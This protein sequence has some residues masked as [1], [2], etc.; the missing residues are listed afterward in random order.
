MIRRVGT[1]FPSYLA[2]NLIF[3]K[4]FKFGGASIETVDRARNVA[5]L[6]REFGN[7]SLLVVISAKG[8]TTNALEKVVDAYCLG[9]TADAQQLFAELK[10]EHIAYAQS[11]LGSYPQTLSDKLDEIAV[12]AE[13]ILAEA[14]VRSY[15]YYYDQLVSIGELLSTLIIEAYLKHE[16]ANSTWMDVRDVMKTDDT[17]RDAQVDWALTQKQVDTIFK[18]TFRKASIIITQGFIGCTDENATVTLGR[19]GSDY[20]AAVFANCLD[21]ESVTIWKDVPSLLNADPKIFPDTVP[22]PNISFKEV[23]EM[24]YYGA[25]VIHPKTI[26]PLQN[27]DIPLYVKCFLDKNLP[28]TCISNTREVIAYPPIMVLKTKQTL[29]QVSTRDYS[30]IT[31][32]NL[33]RIYNLF[34]A[35]KIKINLIQN[36]AISFLAC[37]DTQEDKIAMVLQALEQDYEVKRNEDLFLFTVRHYTQHVLDEEL[38][39]R[40]VLLEQR[41]R[42]TIQMVVK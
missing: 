7:E 1:P 9:N 6:I 40:T 29:L 13:W 36:A 34:H 33:S 22:I 17:Y 28:G 41:T 38:K 5:A 23:I 14:P 20:S 11:L 39:N 4:V 3:M 10:N 32:D 2:G 12:E 25:Q 19:E 35:C 15:D 16:G 30:F 42:Q 37:I 31:E 21:A 8:K 26:K 27:K 18:E 24:A